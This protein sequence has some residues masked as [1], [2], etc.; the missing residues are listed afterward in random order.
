MTQFIKREVVML[1]RDTTLG[2]TDKLHYAEGLDIKI[3]TKDNDFKG[4]LSL[5]FLSDE[6]IKDGD[7]FKND[8]GIWQCNNGIIPTG[9]NPKK[10]IAT[11]NNSLE[12]SLDYHKVPTL[13]KTKITYFES[14]PQPSQ[15]WIKY[16][17]EEYNKDNIITEIEIK[18]KLESYENRFTNTDTNGIRETD[19][20][21]GKTYN[22]VINNDNTINIKFPVKQKSIIKLSVKERLYTRDEVNSIVTQSILSTYHKISKLEGDRLIKEVKTFSNK[23][24]KKNLN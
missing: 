6:P 11:T 12:I 15:E 7:Y 16:S 10:I 5:Y 19:K 8:D 14:L 20:E 17:I 22:L 3:Y 21:W 2:K 13:D 18:Y 4:N 9:L 1:P 23:W 24:I